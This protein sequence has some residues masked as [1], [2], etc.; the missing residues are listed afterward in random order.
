MKIK[1]TLIACCL[2]SAAFSQIT[3]SDYTPFYPIGEDPNFRIMS[4]YRKDEKILFEVNPVERLSIYNNFM[5]GLSSNYIH[6]QA[7]YISINPQFRVYTGNS[8]PVKTPSYKG[9]IGTQHL[10]RLTPDTI[11]KMQHFVGFSVESGHYSNGQTGSAF[12]NLYA[13]GSKSSDSIYNTINSSTDLSSILNRKSG[14]FSTNLTSLIINYRNYRLN[15]NNITRRMHSLNIGYT[16]YHNKFLGVGNF[17]GYSQAD[18]LI[19]GRNRYTASYEYVRVFK[20]GMGSR[21][22]L[23]ENFEIIQD[24][25]KSVNPV[26]S[27]TMITYYPF[28]KS[29]GLGFFISYI[30]GHDNYN[31][32][33]VDSGQQATVGISWNQFPSI[34][35]T[36]NE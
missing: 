2:F 9:F 13:D 34:P 5:K 15:K 22:S 21:I 26:R 27:E 31:Y 33:F 17:G 3:F 10:Y 16:R 28:C 35:L 24:A 4:S 23:K 6:T 14:N 11:R 29:K 32:R 7:W 25:H 18:I 1:L 8:F 19:Y 20:D 30:N 12:S 36:G